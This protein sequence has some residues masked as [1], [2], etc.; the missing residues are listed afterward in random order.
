MLSRKEFLAGSLLLAAAPGAF[1]QEQSPLP[2]RLQGP[3]GLPMGYRNDDVP[4]F[5]RE[6][7]KVAPLG[8]GGPASQA[9]VAEPDLQ[10]TLY[11]SPQDINPRRGSERGIQINSGPG[12]PGTGHL[13]TGLCEQPSAMSLRDRNNY[14]DLSGLG[15]I[16]WLTRVTG[17]HLV[18]PIVKLADGTWLLGEHGDGSVFDY[19]WGEFT[20]T[21]T[22]W[23]GIDMKRV[24]TLGRWLDKV[25]LSKV[26]EVG[27]ADLLPGSGHGDGGYANLATFEVYGRAVPRAAAV[28]KSK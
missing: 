11:G 17:L 18:R 23:I 4:L 10:L 12:V 5:F 9:N 8:H 21:E 3:D 27:F 15:K 20:L 16:R 26:D 13:F 22:R 19:H 28:P 6:P 24:V 14:V 25:D 1:A 7:W 2:E